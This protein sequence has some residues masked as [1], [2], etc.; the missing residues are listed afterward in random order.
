LTE[1]NTSIDEKER[2]ATAFIDRD[3]F[4]KDRK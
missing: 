4:W 3:K 1:K 2:N